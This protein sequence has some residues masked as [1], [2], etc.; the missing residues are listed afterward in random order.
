MAPGRDRDLAAT[1]RLETFRGLASTA[2]LL[3]GS[4]D[5]FLLAADLASDLDKAAHA[6]R[7]NRVPHLS[8]TSNKP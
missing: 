3:L 6:E 2:H 4:H 7:H 1:S 8:L 5:P